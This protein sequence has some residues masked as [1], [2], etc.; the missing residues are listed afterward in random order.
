M[1]PVYWIVLSD[2]GV[3]DM[4]SLSGSLVHNQGEAYLSAGGVGLPPGASHNEL[5]L[6]DPVSEGETD[7]NSMLDVHIDVSLRFLPAGML[8]MN[9]PRLVAPQRLA[10]T[11]SVVQTYVFCEILAHDS[12]K[13]MEK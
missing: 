6:T 1:G 9:C 10:R 7:P 8:I 13:T 12:S 11:A 3:V 2:M 5:A 4:V